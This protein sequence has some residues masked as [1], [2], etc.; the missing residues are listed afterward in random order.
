MERGIS[1]GNVYSEY[2]QVFTFITIQQLPQRRRE[3]QS[4]K[5]LEQ[6]L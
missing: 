3:G 1:I 5:L 2:L 4:E 6:L